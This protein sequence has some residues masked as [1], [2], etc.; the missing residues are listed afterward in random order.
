[1]KIQHS[2]SKD[3][4]SIFRLYRIATEYQRLKFADNV[5][6]DFERE[7]VQKE[8]KE[9]RQF[10]LTIEGKIACIWAITYNDPEIW[11]E[12]DNMPSIYVHRIAVDP[13]FRGNNLIADLVEWAKSYATSKGK[14]YIR[15]DT[16]GNNIK[17]IR[18][19]TKAGFEFLG[20]QKLQKVNTLPSH[21]HNA[22]V[23]YFEMKLS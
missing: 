15:L 1:M 10:K 2:T 4:D 13:D 5:W 7:L 23:C 9:Q 8:I 20:M 14:Q 11:G 21:Y 16:C 6:P 17:L 19:Y 22:D 3:I 12:K 18:H